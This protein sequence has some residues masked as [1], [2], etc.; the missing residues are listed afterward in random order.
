MSE[1]SSATAT[2]DPEAV[3][4]ILR[5]DNLSKRAH[6]VF[7]VLGITDW[8]SATTKT[9]KTEYNKKVLL[10]HPDKVKHPKAADAFALITRA[11]K[12]LV[13]EALLKM[14]KKAE[15]A[16][17]G[18]AS[19]SSAAASGA[20]TAAL[21]EEE[22]KKIRQQEE[23]KMKE[24]LREEYMTAVRAQEQTERRRQREEEELAEKEKEK[25]DIY[26]HASDWKKFSRGG[27]SD[28]P[29]AGLGGRRL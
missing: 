24:A 11:Y 13:N 21:S 29:G 8:Q 6:S 2:I 19:S 20:S 14:A 16:K 27:V 10:T 28:G 4:E 12:K 7:E 22:K 9:V 3:K 26:R 18:I 17:H 23:E 15:E 25:E 1:S 5:I